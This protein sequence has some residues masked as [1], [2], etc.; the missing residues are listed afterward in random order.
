M[1]V[2]FKTLKKLKTESAE[3]RN[4]KNKLMH[5]KRIYF[6]NNSLYSPSAVLLVLLILTVIGS[7]TLYGYYYIREARG[8]NTKVISVPKT[9]I[10]Q[11]TDADTSESSE[12]KGSKSL[13]Q[14]NGPESNQIEYLPPNEKDSNV[15]G[16]TSNKTEN[17]K[18]SSVTDKKRSPK[19]RAA[20]EKNTAVKATT[21][22]S[23]KP[24]AEEVT[25]VSDVEKI[26]L[27]NAKKNAKIA[28]LV[29][30]IRLEMEHGSDGQIRKLFDELV[31]LKGQ[32]NSYVLKLKAVWHM[33]NKEFERAEDLLKIVLS[34]D[35]H[36]QEAGINM[37]IVEIK[38][39]HIQKAYER[40]K[41]LREIYPENMRIAEII[42]NMKPLLNKTQIRHLIGDD[43]S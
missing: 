29:G 34:K 30:D 37:A 3:K 12:I 22:N 20:I 15:E 41:N 10:G 2:I 7:G 25:P 4:D 5:R 43:K 42:Q 18:I 23:N 27:E 16:Y 17:I 14:E 6:F 9:D 21:E 26:F 11:P 38:T 36:D 39:Q 40:L 13:N 28:R 1:S 33:H 31:A 19:A 32:D 8:G 35:E 24:K